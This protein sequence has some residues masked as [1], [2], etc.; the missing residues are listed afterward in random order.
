MHEIISIEEHGQ[1]LP[2]WQKLGLKNQKL[3][4]F[5]RHLDYRPIPPK[6]INNILKWEKDKEYYPIRKFHYQDDYTFAWGIDDFLYAAHKL[7]IISEIFWVYPLK[8]QNPKEI[9][10]KLFQYMEYLP[11]IGEEFVKSFKFTSYGAK[12]QIEGLTIHILSPQT[13]DFLDDGNE[14]LVDFDLDFFVTKSGT[15]LYEVK[16]I[17]LLLNNFK[18]KLTYAS[19][20]YSVSSGF[21]PE[22]FRYLRDDLII[23]L[24]L[25]KDVETFKDETFSNIKIISE[26]HINPSDQKALHSFTLLPGGH[27]YLSHFYLQNSQIESCL[28]SLKE[29][30]KSGDLSRIPMYHL[31]KYYFQKQEYEKSLEFVKCVKDEIFDNLDVHMTHLYLLNLCKLNKDKQINK[32]IQKNISTF[33]S[34]FKI[35]DFFSKVCSKDKNSDWLNKIHQHINNIQEISY[36][37]I[38]NR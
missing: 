17:A 20:C 8:S 4:I 37:F 31:A 6:R 3:I 13:L 24:N 19:I 26:H 38:E 21:L 1:V 33:S 9:G 35:L 5:D 22:S 23:E 14:Y 15:K 28:D 25:K 34:N 10:K 11:N 32:F 27:S 29:S 16:E 18:S 2:I 30:R 36:A 7:K 12:T